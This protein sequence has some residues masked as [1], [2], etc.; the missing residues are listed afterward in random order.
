MIKVG[1][2]IISQEHFPD[3]T[4]LLKN[5]FTKEEELQDVRCARDTGNAQGTTIVW[6]FE[7]NEELVSLIFLTRHLRERGYKNIWLHMPYVPNARQDRTKTCEDVFTLRYFCEVINSLNFNRV[8]VY[9]PHSSVTPALLDRVVVQTPDELFQRVYNRVRK[10][11]PGEE[12]YM[13]YPD[14][15]AMKRYSSSFKDDD[16][17]IIPHCFGI[18]KRDWK[19]GQIR[20]L[21]IVGHVEDYIK[22]KIVLIADDIC[23]RGGT[24]LHSARQLKELGAKKVYLVVSHCEDTIFSGELLDGDLIERVYTTDSIYT[25]EHPKIEVCKK[26]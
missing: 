17:D 16:G 1:H 9:D 21:S 4:L 11:N 13:F 5:V 3:G 25:G 6:K 15:G 23:S 24:F 19:T 14:E 2:K 20:G 10:N 7:N 18:K 22:D 8:F 26:F 12:V